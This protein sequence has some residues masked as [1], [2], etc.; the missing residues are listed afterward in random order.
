MDNFALE[1]FFHVVMKASNAAS[2]APSQSYPQSLKNFLE[3]DFSVD[4]RWIT[5]G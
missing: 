3:E 2:E 1:V 4:N 5:Q